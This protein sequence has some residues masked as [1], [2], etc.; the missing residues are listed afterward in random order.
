VIWER[1]STSGYR[2]VAIDL[3]AAQPKSRAGAKL[4]CT[5]LVRCS[6]RQREQESDSSPVDRELVIF[7]T[8][9]YQT[10]SVDSETPNFNTNVHVIRSPFLEVA[11]F[12]F[13]LD[14]VRV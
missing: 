14:C 13:A 10:I 12:L 9:L 7:S 1:K 4:R 5:F 3:K 8:N 6:D 2:A 11:L